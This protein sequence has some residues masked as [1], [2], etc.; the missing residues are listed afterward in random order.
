MQFPNFETLRPD[1]DGLVGALI[2]DENEFLR[3]QPEAIKMLGYF[4]REA[5]GVTQ[6]VGRLVLWSPAR[7]DL[8]RVGDVSG[9]VV[10]P[11]LAVPYYDAR[12]LLVLGD[13]S[14]RPSWFFEDPTGRK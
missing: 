10:V 6:R 12:S 14:G 11:K 2:V 13:C 4:N 3:G 1:Y 7:Q 9:E 5:Y 8:W